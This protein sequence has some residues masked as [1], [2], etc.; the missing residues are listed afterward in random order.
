MIAIIYCN[1]STKLQIN[2]IDYFDNTYFGNINKIIN[3]LLFYI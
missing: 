3:F 1:F 2:L